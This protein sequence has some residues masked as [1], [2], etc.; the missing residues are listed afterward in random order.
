MGLRFTEEACDFVFRLTGGHP[1]FTRQ[2]CSFVS[3]QFQDRP[4]TISEARVNSVLDSYMQL[5]GK[6]FREIMD[7]LDRD[8][9][10]ERDVCVR[11]AAVDGP[12]RVEELGL[13]ARSDYMGLRHL[14]GYQIVSVS[15][16]EV[17]LTMELLRRWLRVR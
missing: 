10:G 13:E 11:L 5:A 16:G 4:L 9:P 17:S 6:D 3:N 7:R 8:Y 14:I 12:M 15:Q 1:F 2:L